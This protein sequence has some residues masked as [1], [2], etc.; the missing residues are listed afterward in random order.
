MSSLEELS[1][2]MAA[3]HWDAIMKV[4]EAAKIAV[5]STP[6]REECFSSCLCWQKEI[7]S[8]IKELEKL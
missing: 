7:W 6:H 3:K 1:I 2:G 5:E 4:L 8:A